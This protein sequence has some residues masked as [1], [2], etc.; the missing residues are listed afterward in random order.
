M[1]TPPLLF[2]RPKTIFFFVSNANE[3]KVLKREPLNKFLK[4]AR[5]NP[6]VNDFV[7]YY[8]KL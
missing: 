7:N 8:T 1:V 3:R 4:Y 6:F 2:D 5:E